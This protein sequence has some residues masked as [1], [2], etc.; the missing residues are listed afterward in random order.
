MADH[1]EILISHR[2]YN[3]QEI[4]FT[5]PDCLYKKKTK[6]VPSV[7]QVLNIFMFE[8]QYLLLE[9]YFQ[10]YTKV[11]NS[12]TMKCYQYKVNTLQNKH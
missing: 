10:E 8:E 6:L 12:R 7:L 4:T 2:S 5:H 1:Q 11:S 9:N 3:M